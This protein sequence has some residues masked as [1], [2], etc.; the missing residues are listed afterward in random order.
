MATNQRYQQ[1]RRRSDCVD[2]IE[3]AGHSISQLESRQIC[4]MRLKQP[5]RHGV[6][7]LGL[8]KLLLFAT[9]FVSLRLP[10][11]GYFLPNV[12]TTRSLYLTFHLSPTDWSN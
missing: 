10:H 1:R 6:P 11:S 9:H 7:S 3:L 4:G 2:R 8:P 12:I 5:S